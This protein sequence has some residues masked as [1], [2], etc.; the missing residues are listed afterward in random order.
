MYAKR[1]AEYSLNISVFQTI[2]VNRF[3]NVQIH[4]SNR[5]KKYNRNILLFDII[6]LNDAMSECFAAAFKTFILQ[7]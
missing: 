7:D 3:R 5:L 1:Q 6:T 2:I 4:V